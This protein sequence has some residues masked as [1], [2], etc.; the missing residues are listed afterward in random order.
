MSFAS[1]A[2]RELTREPA[3]S[4]AAAAAELAAALMS[5]G[6]VSFRGKNRYS[7]SFTVDSASIIRYFFS[8]IKR[9]FGIVCEI[10]TIRTAQLGHRLR[11]RLIVPEDGCLSLLEA[12]DMRDEAA[13]F[14]VRGE[15]TEALLAPEGCREAFLRGAF[16]VCGTV[17]N[18]E[19]A[20]SLEFAVGSEALAANIMK[21]LRYFEI[22][23]KMTCRKGQYVVYL[24]DSERIVDL[25]ARIGAHKAILQI[26]N[27]RIQKQLVN[28]VNRQ[29]NC[30]SNNIRRTVASSEAQVRDIL[31]IDE[32]IGL[33]KLSKPLRDVANARL[34][35][36][37]TSLAGLGEMLI[38]PIGKSGVNN[39]LRRL[40]AI[41]EKLRCGEDVEL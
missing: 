25:L 4:R 41:A 18:P 37:D 32:Q 39:R 29:V 26:E 23:A 36:R 5:L 27:I 31:Y 34:N 2:R 3:G 15:P 10:R 21:T 19:R 7:I 14:G 16:M 30:D 35:N 1:D 6:A 17:T 40:S 8:Q 22:C 13:W 24:K 28:L 9:H 33:D 38:P 20:Y 12:L 11:Y